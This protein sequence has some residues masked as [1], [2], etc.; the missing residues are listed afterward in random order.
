MSNAHSNRIAHLMKLSAHLAGFFNQ[1]SYAKRIGDPAI[2]DFV[3]GNPHE[4]VIPGLVPAL[5][6]HLEPQN[7]DW[8]AYKGNEKASRQHVAATLQ[9]WRGIPFE[10]PDIFLTNGAFAALSVVLTAVADPGDEVIFISPPWFFYETLIAAA[11]AVPVR[12]KCDMQTFDLDLEAI[13]AAITD[14]TRA[15]IVNTPNNPTGRIYSPDRLAALAQLLEKATERVGRPIYLMSDEAYSRIVFDGQAFHSPTEFYPRTFLIYTY[16]KTLLAPGQ[17]IGYIALP[18]AMPA[19]EQIRPALEVAQ[20]ATGY[21]FPNALMQYALPDIEAL[22]IDVEHYQ[23][24]RDLMVPALREMGY[25]V[26]SPA[27]T[28]YLMVRSPIEDDLAFAERLAAEDVFVLPGAVAE[29]PG[30]FRVSLTA[31]EEMIQRALPGFAKAI[32]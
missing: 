3:F 2:A 16:T 15:V 12:V 8:F 20:Y 19:R 6:T 4:P 25:E 31:N 29:I 10:P 13:E 5:Q 28:F 24:K 32:G 30:Y 22:S 7:K 17:R 18:P 14:K 23:H 26:N 11:G 27:G 21:A 1:S 9:D